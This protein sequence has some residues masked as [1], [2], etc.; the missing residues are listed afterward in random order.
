MERHVLENVVYLELARRGGEIYVGKAGES[1]IDFV[2]V[3]GDRKAYY[4]VSLSV[5]NEDTIKRE[6]EPL[7]SISDNFPK[8]LLTMD[9]DPETMHDGIRQ[10]YVLDWLMEK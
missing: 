2:V 3:K 5:R 10:Q 4:Q 9:N 6:L 1:E 7:R 8:Y